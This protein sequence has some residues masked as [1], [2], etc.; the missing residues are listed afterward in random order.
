MLCTQ[1]RLVRLALY[2]LLAPKASRSTC[3]ICGGEDRRQ[4]ARTLSAR[5]LHDLVDGHSQDRV[6]CVRLVVDF[7]VFLLWRQTDDLFD[8]RVSVPSGLEFPFKPFDEFNK[9]PMIRRVRPNLPMALCL[10]YQA[11]AQ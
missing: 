11:C 2:E 3:T 6:G 5:V 10:G 9:V 4:L 1:F 8:R 7:L